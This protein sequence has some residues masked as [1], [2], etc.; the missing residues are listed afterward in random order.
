MTAAPGAPGLPPTW[1][2]SAKEMVGCSLALHVLEID[3]SRLR[4]GRYIDLT[5]RSGA[6]WIGTD[7]RILVTPRARQP[8]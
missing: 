4:A 3:T 7:F 8:G 1:C 6:N 2:S 5:F